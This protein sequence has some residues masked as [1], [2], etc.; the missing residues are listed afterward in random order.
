MP[1]WCSNHLTIEGDSKQLKEFLEK[2]NNPK[3][4]FSF[5]G[6]YPEPDYETTPVARTYPEVRAEYKEDE[7]KEKILLNEPEIYEACHRRGPTLENV[8][9]EDGT[10]DLYKQVANGVRATAIRAASTPGANKNFVNQEIYNYLESIFG[11][12]E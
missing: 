9:I 2:S 1:N 8:C 12:V 6:T 5:S 11:A 3:I 10:V 4:G 7:E